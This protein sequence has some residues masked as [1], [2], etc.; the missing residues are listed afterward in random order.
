M[1]DPFG[2]PLPFLQALA[3]KTSTPGGGS[4]A[5]LVGA[6]A[7]ALTSM[8]GQFTIGK[9]KFA[10]VEET[11][12]KITERAL[13]LMEEFQVYMRQDAEA[14]QAVMLAYQEKGPD[15]EKHLQ[16]ALKKASEAPMAILKASVEVLQIAETMVQICNPNLR[17]DAG[18]TGV[19][20]L[21]SARV[22][23]WNVR[24]NL[25]ELADQTFKQETL[26]E[27]ERLLKEAVRL[28]KQ[29]CQYTE[30]IFG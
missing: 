13:Q 21:A 26:R 7:S 4:A 17:T 24:M 19:F 11:A 28:E 20:G 25:V 12:K 18:A 15:R 5:A 8:A 22:A 6:I 10:E 23:S 16:D 2:S 14:F 27:V 3:A 1:T 29:I 30:K 9:K